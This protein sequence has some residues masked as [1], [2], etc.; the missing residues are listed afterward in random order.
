MGIKLNYLFF[1]AVIVFTSN[2]FGQSLKELEKLKEEYKNALER[3]AMKMP[4]DV[5]EVEKALMS[6]SEP[7]EVV[8]LK[9]ILNHF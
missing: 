1:I 9:K 3:Q 4:E 8:Y 2:T 6:S 7:S 5:S